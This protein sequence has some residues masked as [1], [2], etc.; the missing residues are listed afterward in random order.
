MSKKTPCWYCERLFIDEKTLIGHQRSKHFSCVDCR[1]CLQ[2]AL[3]LVSHAKSVHGTDIKVVPNSLPGRGDPKH[4]IFGTQGI[5]EQQAASPSST[6]S[7]TLIKAPLPFAGAPVLPRTSA[8]AP[9]FPLPG[10]AFRPPSI[11]PSPHLQSSAYPHHLS[12]L[13]LIANP[14]TSVIMSESGV[15]PSSI[16]SNIASTSSSHSQLTFDQTSLSTSSAH[17]IAPIPNTRKRPVREPPT[18]VT[19]LW[20]E[21]DISMEEKRLSLPKYQAMFL[22]LE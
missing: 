22:K 15:T 5:P 1:K 12:P 10:A 14:S 9:L 16:S 3:S 19:L 18:P 17:P 20:T 13:S 6:S 11:F 2:S 21:E 4:Q 8:P 7:D